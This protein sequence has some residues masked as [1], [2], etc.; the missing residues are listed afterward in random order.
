[1]RK[2]F[3]KL[4]NITLGHM[5]QQQQN[6]HTTRQQSIGNT[7]EPETPLEPLPGCTNNVYVN[8]FDT[9]G[10]IYIDLPGILPILSN[11]R[12]QK[13]F[14]LYD[15]KSNAILSKPIKISVILK[16]WAHAQK[17]WTTSQNV[18]SNKKYSS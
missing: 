2:H 18:D 3:T 13:L 14:I 9:A 4:M 7:P 17:I 10:K 5:H 8:T 15:F 6:M 11:S 16:W 1:M 12:N